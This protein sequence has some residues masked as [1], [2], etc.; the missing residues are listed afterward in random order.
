MV[1]SA[2]QY[3]SRCNDQVP[4]CIA[5]HRV[6]ACLDDIKGPGAN[7]AK[8]GC[9]EA[10]A[11]GLQ[12]AQLHA[13]T[14]MLAPQQPTQHRGLKSVISTVLTDEAAHRGNMVIGTC[15]LDLSVHTHSI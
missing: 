4:I 2:G 15:A 14:F 6:Q 8:A 3:L 11:H 12:W 1:N 13:I 10:G 7:R 9:R 5:Q